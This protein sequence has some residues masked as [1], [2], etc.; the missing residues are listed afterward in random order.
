[1]LRELGSGQVGYKKYELVNVM[2]RKIIGA[3]LAGHMSKAFMQV[4]ANKHTQ[5]R[6]DFTSARAELLGPFQVDNPWRRALSE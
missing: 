4:K 6:Q 2:V 5:K 3:H 1:M